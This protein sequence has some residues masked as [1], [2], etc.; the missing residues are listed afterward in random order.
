MVNETA[1]CYVIV[2]EYQI[3]IKAVMFNLI[4]LTRTGSLSIK[5]T[6]RRSSIILSSMD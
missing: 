1:V 3:N 6:I 5:N 4:K 2:T